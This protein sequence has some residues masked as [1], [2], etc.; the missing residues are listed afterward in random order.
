ME[1]NWEYFSK[2]FLQKTS[3]FLEI[4]V[5]FQVHFYHQK[6]EKKNKKDMTVPFA[7]AWA[8]LGGSICLSA[9]TIFISLVVLQTKTSNCKTY[10]ATFDLC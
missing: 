6:G 3:I 2:I 9:V 8:K 4:F 7:R 10:F 5:F 1:N